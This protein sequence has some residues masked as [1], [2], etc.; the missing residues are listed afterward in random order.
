MDI[1]TEFRSHWVAA[2]G[3]KHP[4]RRVDGKLRHDLQPIVNLDEVKA[5]LALSTSDEMRRLGF[6]GAEDD[7]RVFYTRQFLREDVPST[8]RERLAPL[9][10]EELTDDVPL[11]HCTWCKAF[12]DLRNRWPGVDGQPVVS[13]TA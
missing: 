1:T 3:T 6:P 5:W 2:D 9:I 12:V 11:Y 7:A 10:C 13:A 8:E 4:T